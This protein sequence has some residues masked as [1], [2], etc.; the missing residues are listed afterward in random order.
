MPQAATI[1][2]LLRA[3]RMMKAMC[4]WTKKPAK[5]IVEMFWF[6]SSFLIGIQKP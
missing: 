1:N 4:R 3:F 6:I 2:S 5:Q